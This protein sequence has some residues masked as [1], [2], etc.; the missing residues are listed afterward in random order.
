MPIKLKSHILEKL[1]LQTNC[2]EDELKSRLNGVAI[3][4]FSIFHSG[5]SKSEILNIALNGCEDKVEILNPISRIEKW[6]YHKISNDTKEIAEVV[7]IPT[8]PYDEPPREMSIPP[9]T[10]ENLI[11]RAWHLSKEIIDGKEQLVNNKIVVLWRKG[12][13]ENFSEARRK[14]LYALLHASGGEASSMY[15]DKWWEERQKITDIILGNECCNS[16]YE[17]SNSSTYDMPP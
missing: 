5:E 9:T 16:N 1:G 12:E 10:A 13:Y 6:C 8:Y 17:N 14:A 4:S 7:H 2:T 11:V 3:G 15:D